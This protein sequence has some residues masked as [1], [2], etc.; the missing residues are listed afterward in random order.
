LITGVSSGIGRALALEFARRGDRIV[1]IARDRRLLT[2]LEREIRSEGGEGIMIPCDV[3]NERQV[4]A[5]VR[6]GTASFGPCDFLVNNAGVTSFKSFLA[7]PVRTFDEILDTN[8]KGAMIATRTVLPSMVRR[9]KGTI[10]NIVS[11]AAKTVYT[12]ASAY[13]AAKAGLAKMMDVIREEV[14]SS[15][16]KVINVYPGA[17]LTPMWAPKQRTRF[18]DEMIAP[19]AFAAMLYELSVQ[20]AS[21]TVEEVVV[22]PPIGDLR[23]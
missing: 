10:I 19:G 5:A 23:V 21:M 9:K 1:G 2:L 8:L 13:S 17:I 15:G 14:R 4:S 11:Y 12:G 3:R 20:P 18:R 6:K 22:R 7:T 16:V